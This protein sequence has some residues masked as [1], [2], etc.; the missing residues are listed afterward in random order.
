MKILSLETHASSAEQ[1]N[2]SLKLALKIIM[3]EKSVGK[4][5]QQTNQS[6]EVTA[7]QVNSRSDNAQFDERSNQDE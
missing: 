5:Q 2:D 6:Y 4:R 3:Q 7:A 1:E